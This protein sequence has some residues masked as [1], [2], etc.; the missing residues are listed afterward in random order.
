MSRHRGL[1]NELNDYEAGSSG[2]RSASTRGFHPD[3]VYFVEDV[4][5]ELDTT[6]EQ[7]YKKYGITMKTLVDLVVK[8]DYDFEACVEVLERLV[9]TS[10]V[11]KLEK[12]K[13][14]VVPKP[15]VLQK[16]STSTTTKSSRRKRSKKALSAQ[17]LREMKDALPKEVLNV[18]VIGHVDAGKSTLF[19][20]LLY[21]LGK[22][23][24]K[25]LRDYEASSKALGKSSFKFAW[26]LDQH[27]TEREKGVTIDVGMN[28]FETENKSIVLLDAPGHKDFV[29]NMVS[30]AAQAD[31]A[32]LV[33]PATEFESAFQKHAQTK[34]HAMLAKYLGVDQII[35]AVSKMDKIPST[36]R[37]TRFEFIRASIARFFEKFANFSSVL[38]V[39]VSGWEGVNLTT[40]GYEDVV[41]NGKTLVEAMDSF[42]SSSSYDL[43]HNPLRIVVS[44]VYKSHLFNAV[45]ISGKIHSGYVHKGDDVA[46]VPAGRY[47]KIKGLCSHDEKLVDASTAGENVQVALT[48]YDPEFDVSDVKV[49]DVLSGSDDV[50]PLARAITATVRTLPGLVVPLFVGA[51]YTLF[52]HSTETP[53]VVE[54]IQS[55]RDQ[56]PPHRLVLRDSTCDLTLR[57]PKPVPLER[58][59]DCKPLGRILLREKGATLGAGFVT[60]ILETKTLNF[61]D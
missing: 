16:S 40:K 31:A 48:S 24:K 46:L 32:V 27:D 47:L 20:H 15:K 49:G 35:V 56:R 5:Y 57:L 38:F 14:S 52:V 37:T 17:T 22:I 51:H 10:G 2:A 45:T 58:I 21:K 61:I 59:R 26:V 3:D 25:T 30:G 12:K 42:S 4:V 41:E 29:P 13:K 36:D 55:I 6:S 28:K 19:G 39:P 44:D 53:V 34:E 60:E 8:E 1:K 7:L 54:S 18:V 11:R 43:V 9:A 50:V 23:D 33:V